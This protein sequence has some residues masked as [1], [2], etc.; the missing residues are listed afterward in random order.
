MAAFDHDLIVLG[1]GSAGV[2]CAR[3]SASLGAKVALVEGGPMG[4]TCVNVGCVPKKLFSIGAH[5][6][7]DLEDAA[8]FGWSVGATAFDWPT[9][10]RNKDAEIARLNHIYEGILE[11]AGVT[12]VRGWATLAGPH[13]VRVG[14]Q[15]L[16]GERIVLCTG[17]RPWLPSFPGSEHVMVSD[18]LFGLPALPERMIVV[19]GGYIAVELASI[20]HGFGV[21]VELLYRGSLFLRGFD[22]ECRRHLADAMRARGVTLHFDTQPQAVERDASGTYRVR[23][24]DGRALETDAVLYAVGRRPNTRGI[25]LEAL[26]VKMNEHGAVHVDDAFRTSVPSI[27][28]LGDA[29]DRLNLTPVALA[30]GTILAHNLFGGA[31]RRMSY[32]NVATTLFSTPNLATVGLTEEAARQSRARIR[33]YTSSFRP[34][35]NT[36]SGRQER[37]LMKL[38]VD[39]ADDRVIGAHMVGPEAGEL[40]QGVAIAMTCGATKTQFDATLGIH[41]T[42]AEEFVTM[43]TLTRT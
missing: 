3:M 27:Y 39:D 14:D 12:T 23:L 10:L 26:G 2:R 40:I 19:G 24:A 30:E 16:R 5:V 9:L 7:D 37:I 36:L 20:L 31:A 32:D 21:H 41:P 25:G 15:Q 18:D 35:K 8:G 38:V 6:R 28:A 11:R 42:A 29:L 34:M 17:G 4:G 43:R 22:E 13:T 1:G 33:V